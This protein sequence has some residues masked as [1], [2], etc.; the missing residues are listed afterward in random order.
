MTAATSL[1]ALY[2]LL[3]L[4]AAAT[5]GAAA[6]D[7]LG[8]ADRRL[9]ADGLFSRGLHAR[10]AAEYEA[11]ERDFPDQEDLDTV[12]FRW[13]ESLRLSDRPEEAGRILLRIVKDR[14]DSPYRHRALFQRGAIAIAADHFEVA[15]E[16]LGQ[17]LGEN[18]APDLR[19]SALY[20]RAEALAQSA[21]TEESVRLYTAFLEEFPDSALADYARLSLGRTLAA[22]GT[23]EDAETARGLFRKTALEPDTPRLGAEALYL[24]AQ[25]EFAQG[26]YKP[27][28][29]A[30]V[31]LARRFPADERTVATRL[32]AAWAAHRAGLHA[33]T[34]D[35][36]AQALPREDLPQRDEWLY[37]KGASEYQLARYREAI[38]TFAEFNEPLRNS[39]YAG[40]A[41]FQTAVAHQRLGETALATEAAL[42]VPA[43]DPLRQEVL[44]LLGECYATLQ[45]SDRA[46]QYYRLLA[47]EFPDAARVPEALYRLA[48]QLQQREAWTDAAT[49]Y[50]RLA[51]QAPRHTLAPRALF[52]SGYCLMRSGRSAEAVRDWD[53]LIRGYPGEETTHEARFRKGIEEIR[54]G[55]L[56]DA[57]VTIEGFLRDHP[58]SPHCNEARFWHATLLQRKGDLP[59]A[60]QALR[61]VLAAAPPRDLEREATFLLGLVAQQAGRDTEAAQCFQQLLDD[62]LCKRF[63]PKQL[64]WLSDHQFQQGAFEQAEQAA[65]KLAEQAPDDGWR[66]AAWTLAGRAARER[67]DLPAAETAFRNAVNVPGETRYAA[68]AH[69]RLGEIL[70]GGDQTAEAEAAFRQ[71]ARLAA[72]PDLQSIRILA[73][74]GLGRALARKG[75][76]E[77]A[78]RY[79][80]GVCLLNRDATLLPPLLEET[81]LLLRELKH[82]EEA[83]T[84]LNDL[85]ELYPDSEP[86]RRLAPAGKTATP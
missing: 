59:Q 38:A 30:F 6:E 70:L 7:A 31:E 85:L 49:A 22:R 24:L 72:A 45:D 71:A 8:A 66:Q 11:L 14:P 43:E 46:V 17:L 69:L 39:R 62:P 1:R 9:F 5:V 12:L 15:A 51:D 57:R 33:E 75:D 77:A 16:L 40:A 86:A 28:A 18:P 26:R 53:R 67:G 50:L 82:P 10:A 34:L 2:A 3:T 20:F 42:R 83:E 21:Q 73:H 79:L 63:T 74:A 27:S 44:W 4:A 37:L 65:R 52:A 25:C 80:L 54:M 55:R 29:D 68:E 41:A 32:Q 13:A 19:E 56:D 23:P 76:R 81:I 61:A 84:L 47:D 60:E 36:A 58:D 35:M 78:A 48:H 64:A